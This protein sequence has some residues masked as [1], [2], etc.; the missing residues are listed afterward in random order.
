MSLRL[1]RFLRSIPLVESN[2]TPSLAFHQWWDATLKQIETSVQR[3]ELALSAAGIALDNVGVIPAFNTRTVDIDTGLTASDYLVLVDATAA[4][5]TVDLPP[6]ASK[7]GYQIVVKKIDASA[8][9]VTVDASASETIDG[10]TT[11]DLSSQYESV[12]VA[13]DGTEWWIVG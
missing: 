13:S 3:I 10:A 12:T 7:E 11:K 8:N 5:V 1:P 6:A 9:V 4:A 2:G